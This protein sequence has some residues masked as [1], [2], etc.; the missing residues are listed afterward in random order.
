MHSQDNTTLSLKQLLTMMDETQECAVESA[1]TLYTV[2]M[3]Y[4]I[5][6]DNDL[7]SGLT[8]SPNGE[9]CLHKVTC[10]VQPLDYWTVENVEVYKYTGDLTDLVE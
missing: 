1:H 10:S 2:K 6:V 7:L 5:F 3:G 8:I 4:T 9:V